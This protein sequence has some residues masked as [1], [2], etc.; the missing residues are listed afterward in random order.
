[1][2]IGGNATYS[3]VLKWRLIGL[4][5][6]AGCGKDTAATLLLR[7]CPGNRLALASPIK[8][9]LNDLF[10]FR[11]S[12]W[13][14]REWKEAVLPSLGVSPRHLAQTLGTEWGRRMVSQDI[15]LHTAAASAD[16][17][18]NKWL[19]LIITDIRFPN[20]AAWIRGKGGVVVEIKRSGLVQDAHA[21]EAGI[22][23]PGDIV[24]ENFGSLADL[25]ERLLAQLAMPIAAWTAPVTP[26]D[27]RQ[28]YLNG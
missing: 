21:S 20:E 6:L 13:E 4:T 27:Y 12:D 25:S 9:A 17:R 11:D 8:S 15:W 28:E 1:M 5:G 18:F 3:H 14:N 19:P 10:G 7:D 23:G 22:G 24:I 2:G 26:S 16:R